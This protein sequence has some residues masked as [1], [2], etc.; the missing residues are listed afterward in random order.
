MDIILH[1]AKRDDWERARLS[2]SYAADSLTS[3]GFI[4]CSTPQQ[5]VRV[6]NSLFHGQHDLVLLCIDSG[7]VEPE[8]RYE[9][10]EG[11]E[12]RFPHIYGPL[13]VA[14]VVSVLA[15]QPQADG[16]FILPEGLQKATSPSGDRDRARDCMLPE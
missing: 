7:K 11:G 15:F 6:A 3:Q 4:H 2:G 8:I 12:E 9:N 10:L 5:V 14:A 13:N 16:T 1:I